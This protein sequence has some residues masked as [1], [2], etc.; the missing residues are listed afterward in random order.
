VIGSPDYV[1][2]SREFNFAQARA[3]LELLY[4]D[5][6]ETIAEVGFG[7]CLDCGN[8]AVLLRYARKRNLCRRCAQLRRRVARKLEC[9]VTVDGS[10]IATTTTPATRRQEGAGR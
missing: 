9:G 5:G 7:G 4:G 3:T 10:T 1:P 2:A 8:K 6:L